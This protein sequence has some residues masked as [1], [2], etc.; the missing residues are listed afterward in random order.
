MVRMSQNEKSQMTTLIPVERRKRIL[1]MLKRDR[2][3]RVV[4]L[5]ELFDVS[6]VT[7]RRDL[8]LMEEEGL[9]SRSYGGAV[10]GHHLQSEQLYVQKSTSFQY[11]KERIGALAATLVEPGETVFVGSG[12]TTLQ[13]FRHLQ[14]MKLQI[15]TPNAGVITENDLPDLD[16]TLIGG[17]YRRLSNSFVGMTA[18]TMLQQFHASKC[19]IGA[20]GFTIKHGIT[21]ASIDEAVFVRTMAEQTRGKVI[22]LADHSKFGTVASA[23]TVPASM[24]DIIITDPGIDEGYVKDLEN[25]GVEVLIAR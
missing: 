24:L 17:N 10:I 1:D 25:M 16:F 22:L 5:S 2:S 21:S 20:D 11:E 23:F 6:E 15:V 9:L 7:I 19:F 18:M 13:M 3:V 14:E 8:E 12:T 4:E